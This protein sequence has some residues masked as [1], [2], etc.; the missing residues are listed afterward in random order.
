MSWAH[1]WV[2]SA[3]RGASV[4]RFHTVPLVGED[5]VGKHS[6]GVAVLC[7]ALSNYHPSAELLKAA[8]FHDLA[9]QETGDVPAT[10]KWANP[11]IKTLLETVEEQHNQA[12]GLNVTLT[13]EE[14]L[15]LKWADMLDLM[16][17]VVEQRE[18][19]NTNVKVIFERGRDYLSNLIQ[20][21]VG[22]LI[23]SGLVERWERVAT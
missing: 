19:G 22:C 17:F 6:H 16:Y 15:T 5:S 3:R 13:P 20:H 1:T 2:W 18:L 12:M 14:K 9:E 7:C 21:P 8:L 11:Q 10:T 23:L 4:R